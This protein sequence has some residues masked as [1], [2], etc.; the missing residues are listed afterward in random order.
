MIQTLVGECYFI[1]T[2]FQ[3]T[4]AGVLLTANHGLGKL[5]FGL[6]LEILLLEHCFEFCLKSLGVE[7]AGFRRTRINILNSISL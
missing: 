5:L 6:P 1:G 2:E 7:S 4:V 3:K